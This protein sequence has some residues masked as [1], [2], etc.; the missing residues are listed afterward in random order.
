MSIRRGTQAVTRVFRGT[1]EVVRVYQGSHL[2]WEKGAEPVTLD[3]IYI[4]SPPSTT[5]Y[6]SGDALDLTG[7]L[8]YA[9]YSDGME[10]DV[11]SDCVYFPPEGSELIGGGDGQSFVSVGI[12]YS[13]GD[14]TVS[15][16]FTVEVYGTTTLDYSLNA[17]NLY[18]T[19]TGSGGQYSDWSF[20]GYEL[21][22]GSG[23][24]V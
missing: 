11:T 13:D 19:E 20:D 1:R 12:E 24:D 6:Q 22:I 9:T 21:Q 23:G 17:S 7:L 18:F 3:G 10:E 14:V 4:Y 5:S 2:V 8:V 16:S 15:D